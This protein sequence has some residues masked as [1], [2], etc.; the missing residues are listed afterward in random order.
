MGPH[1]VGWVSSGCFPRLESSSI[2]HAQ[3]SR[4][5]RPQCVS[6]QL[7]EEISV[8][9]VSDVMESKDVRGCVRGSLVDTVRY[10][11]GWVTLWMDGRTGKKSASL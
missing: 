1:E 6:F 3:D 7:D 5:D 2:V 8:S 4:R 9:G 11:G 10:N